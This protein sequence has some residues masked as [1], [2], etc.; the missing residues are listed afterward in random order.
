MVGAELLEEEV[1]F[2]QVRATGDGRQVTGAFPSDSRPL[3][4]LIIRQYVVQW[5]T[6]I[7][8]STPRTYIPPTFNP[9]GPDESPSS[10]T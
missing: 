2:L 10:Y 5:S 1:R 4:I 8:F 3:E 7:K 9:P 6:V